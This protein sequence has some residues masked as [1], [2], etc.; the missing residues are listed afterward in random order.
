LIDNARPSRV[1]AM[2]IEGP[3]PDLH[4]DGFYESA[5][6]LLCRR[7]VPLVELT[8]DLSRTQSDKEDLLRDNIKEI[9]ASEPRSNELNAVSDSELP[10]ISVVVPTVV[11]RVEELRNCLRSILELDYPSYEVIVIDNR[12]AIPVDDMLTTLVADFDGVR[13][14]REARPGIS[15]ARNAGVASAGGDIIAFTDDDVRVD[16]RWLRA[17]G[18]RLVLSPQTDAVTGLIVPTELDTPSQIW[19][20]RFYGGFS[21][22][23]TFERVDLETAP[24]GRWLRGSRVIARDANEKE[25]RRFSILGVGAYGAGAN[26]A[27]RRSVIE[28]VG[29]FDVTLGVGTSSRGGEDLAALIDVLW[30]GGRISYDP[31][32][33]VH[34]GHRREYVQLLNQIE[35]YGVGFTAMLTSTIYRDPRHVPHVASQLPEV[36]KWKAIQTLNHLIAR[37]NDRAE[38]T[39]TRDY[40]SSLLV[41]E[42]RGYL[43]G[44]V[45]YIRSRARWRAINARDSSD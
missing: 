4:S 9:L 25:L 31:R 2:D 27:F 18:T 29:G 5:T 19:F 11:E 39:N 26:M 7:G 41:R 6:I 28:R 44:P 20:E 16:R 3:L 21:G 40:P 15:A 13:I 36:M 37:K 24:P 23:R 34:H 17:I 38:R 8:I 1:V 10:R 30:A 45:A 42:M 12:R 22:Q 33:F 43:K 35:G 14:I 32:A